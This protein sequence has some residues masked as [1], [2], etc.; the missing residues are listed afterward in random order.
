MVQ[1][2]HCNLQILEKR[3]ILQFGN[4]FPFDCKK[5]GCPA[6]DFTVFGTK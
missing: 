5:M 1:V 2:R 3:V 6:H 4:L